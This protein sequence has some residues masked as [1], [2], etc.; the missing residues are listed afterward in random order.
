MMIAHSSRA[1]M[2]A[3][4][5][6]CVTHVLVL[7]VLIVGTAFPTWAQDFQF[8]ATGA[9]AP[10]S[11]IA[12]LA[13]PQG[14][15]LDNGI[16]DDITP[17][18]LGGD[19]VLLVPPG[20]SDP[21]QPEIRAGGNGVI[22]SVPASD[23]TLSAV[24]CPGG[25]NILQ[26]IPSG[27]DLIATSAIRLCQLCAGGACIIP[28][29]NGVLE[30]TVDPA[31]VAVP[32]VSTGTD[33]IA[34]T[35]A[36]GDDAQQVA[37][38]KGSPDTVCVDAG[39]NHIVDTTLC[40]NGINDFQENGPPPGMSTRCDDGN[41]TGIDGCS[42]TCEV[43]AGWDC[44]NTIG[45]LSV[46]TPHCGDGLVVGGEACDDGNT[47]NDDDCLN[48]CQ[49]E[50]CGDGFVHTRGTPPF[51][52]CEPPNSANCDATCHFLP[53]CGDGV[54]QPGEECDDG[55]TRND[56]ACVLGCKNAFCGDGFLERG[57][58][59]CEP[60]NTATCDATCHT[61]HPPRCGD[62]VVDPGE[63]CDD[64]NSSNQDD[65][66]NTCQL[67]TCGDN[68]IHNKGTPPF[69]ECDDGNTTPGDGC[70]AT[71]LR[72]CGNGVI[73]GG[74]S[75]GTVGAAC[76]SN[77][78]CDTMSG[79]GDGVCVA[80]ACDPGVAN[81]CIPG[82]SECSNACR[83]AS[84]GNG[85]LECDEEC[86]FGAASNGVPGSGCT[87]TCTRNVVGKNESGIRECLNAWTLDSPPGN[88]GQRTQS[89]TDGAPCDFDSIPG[90]CTFRVGVCLNRPGIVG[91]ERGKIRTFDVGGLRLKRP[92]DAAALATITQAVAA[93]APGAA[94]VPDHCRAGARGLT[95]VIPNNHQCDKLLGS[96]DGVCDLGASVVFFPPLDPADAGGGQL[97]N[98][99]PGQDIVVKTNSVLRLTSRVTKNTGRTDGDKLKLI[100]RP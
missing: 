2:T 99:T 73:D 66:L 84:C 85:E 58:E 25:D 100:C 19:D 82:P 10:P 18:L 60:P 23:D 33:G 5:L 80:E 31:D 17:A 75:E 48:T 53:F 65:C 52:Q 64:G 76:N 24:I 1:P 50:S 8:R 22:D 87:A 42:A 15:L 47:R 38:G 4:P 63:A 71:C 40:G 97:S 20:K 74:C 35:T 59:E 55:N 29:A 61:I 41:T 77:D 98:C 26:S 27:D 9:M 16:C 28:G 56:D 88:L 93:L 68:F 37:V 12:I 45:T 69:E 36:A 90:Q 83:V 96:N 39:L 21:Y 46:C 72:E 78:D 3:R 30:T 44:S 14:G 49:P 86:D 67:P 70:S 54:V 34:Q 32:F 95:C 92:P 57:V 81:F 7:A 11:N 89:C 79:A 91:C 62:R 6:T 51:E 43:E 94:T 13:G